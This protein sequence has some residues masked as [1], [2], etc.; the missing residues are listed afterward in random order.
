MHPSIPAV[1]GTVPEAMYVT[2]EQQ[3]GISQM[4]QA[5]RSRMIKRSR[6]TALALSVLLAAPFFA[7]AQAP[8]PSMAVLFPQEPPIAKVA[9]GMSNLDVLATEDGIRQSWADYVLLLDGD[10]LQ[11]DRSAWAERL[12]TQDAKWRQFGPDRQLVTAANGPAEID[13]L[14][15]RSNRLQ[16][17]GKQMPVVLRFDEITPTTVKTRTV[18]TY[19][20]IPLSKTPSQPDGVPAVVGGVPQSALAVFHET[21]RKVEGQWLISEMTIYTGSPGFPGSRIPTKSCPNPANKTK[22]C[23]L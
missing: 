9:A 11:N 14:L 19:L 10:G 3:K 2:F 20:N 4:N 23:E 13:L 16:S 7:R 8:A 6:L 1:A 22:G 5:M 12:F 15:S 17:T 18:V 21:W